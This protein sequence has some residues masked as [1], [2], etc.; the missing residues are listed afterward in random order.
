MPRLIVPSSGG[1]TKLMR[2]E[3]SCPTTKEKAKVLNANVSKNLLVIPSDLSALTSAKAEVEESPLR[4]LESFALREGSQPLRVAVV[5]P[6]QIAQKIIPLLA[7]G[8]KSRIGLSSF[9]GSG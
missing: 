4:Y 7:F 6:L 9:K 5:A 1:G 2:T 8:E 3:C